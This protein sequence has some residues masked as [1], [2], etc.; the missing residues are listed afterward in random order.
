[1]T[2]TALMAMAATFNLVCSGT[3]WQ[4]IGTGANSK[5]NFKEFT[6]TYRVDLDSRR[7]C[8]DECKQTQA[9]FS[10]DANE[11]VFSHLDIPEENAYGDV[12]VNRESGA[13]TVTSKWLV[14]STI[15]GGTCVRAP[16]TGFPSRKF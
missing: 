5:T 9:F 3:S 1:M 10:I 6:T 14:S 11:L 15:K 7:W 8:Q 12:S 16:F 4:V 13:Y 2:A